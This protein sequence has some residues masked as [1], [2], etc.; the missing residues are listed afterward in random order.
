MY[1]CV[2]THIHQRK[3]MGVLLK[4]WPGGCRSAESETFFQVSALRATNLSGRGRLSCLSIAVRVWERLPHQP[5]SAEQGPGI[6]RR[7]PLWLFPFASNNSDF[8]GLKGKGCP[9]LLLAGQARPRVGGEL[10]LLLSRDYVIKKGRNKPKALICFNT[11]YAC[12]IMGL[13]QQLLSRKDSWVTG[14]LCSEAPGE[15][16]SLAHPMATAPLKAGVWPTR[17]VSPTKA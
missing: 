10:A 1:V 13:S 12:S 9:W 11:L 7:P 8:T 14:W 17:D 3:K 5:S 6:G 2:Y 15:S 4:V 16:P